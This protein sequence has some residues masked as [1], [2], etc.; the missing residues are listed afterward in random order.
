MEHNF[1]LHSSS[2]LIKVL[3]FVF[4]PLV[5]FPHGRVALF[6]PELKPWT[7][8]SSSF[9]LLFSDFLPVKRLFFHR[10]LTPPPHGTLPCSSPAKNPHRYGLESAIGSEESSEALTPG[11]ASLSGSSVREKISAVRR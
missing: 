1:V 11:S 8:L 5:F 6:A 3:E 10:C 4:I 2:P 9:P 7:L